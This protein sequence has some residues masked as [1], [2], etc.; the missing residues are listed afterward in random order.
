MVISNFLAGAVFGAVALAV[1]YK[2]I[3]PYVRKCYKN[4]RKTRVGKEPASRKITNVENDSMFYE[5]KGSLILTGQ[6]QSRI[7]EPSTTIKILIICIIVIAI[8]ALVYFMLSKK[9]KD[10][11]QPTP[12][13][14]I[15]K[16]DKQKTLDSIRKTLNDLHD[17]GG[18][19]DK[20][21]P[22]FRI[23]RYPLQ[24]VIL[25]DNQI[26]EEGDYFI[27]EEDGKRYALKTNERMN[28][29]AGQYTKDT[30]N[31]FIEFMTR[32]HDN[33]VR[34]GGTKSGVVAYLKG[35][36]DLLGEENFTGALLTPDDG[37]MNVLI[38]SKIRSNHYLNKTKPVTI[39]QNFRNADLPNLR[40]NYIRK[41][42]LGLQI[43]AEILDGEVTTK[44]SEFDRN[45]L[46]LI[47]V[48]R[49]PTEK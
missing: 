4:T 18:Y 30:N 21:F 5:S 29:D 14:Q 20:K 9:Q 11:T 39:N 16:L 33:I 43:N 12:K 26:P 1:T 28:F 47:F 22:Q 10:E 13:P 34:A 27:V 41:I 40:A 37:S 3:V 25:N 48:P 2:Y 49:K 15:V 6:N 46:T 42:F 24:D 32:F 19:V 23:K 17:S 31:Q 8:S 7:K 45:V 44:I 38:K 35:S 36:A